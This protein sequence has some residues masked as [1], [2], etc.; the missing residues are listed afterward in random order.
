MGPRAELICPRP[1]DY[2]GATMLKVQPWRSD[3]LGS[4]ASPATFLLEGL[5]SNDCI[6]LSLSFLICKMEIKII[7]TS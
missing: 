3:R 5:W 7:P 4:S 6:S 2:L 1:H